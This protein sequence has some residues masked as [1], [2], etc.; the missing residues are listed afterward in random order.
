MV[1]YSISVLTD[2]QQAKL[3][4]QSF[5]KQDWCYGI[6]LRDGFTAASE[7]PPDPWS[8]SVVIRINTAEI[9]I[10]LFSDLQFPY[11]EPRDV[12]LSANA[13]YYRHPRWS[14]VER[15]TLCFQNRNSQLLCQNCR[16]KIRVGLF[17]FAQTTQSCRCGSRFAHWSQPKWT[18]RVCFCSG[19]SRIKS[20]HCAWDSSG[21]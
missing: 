2:L 17:P 6:R 1:W 5:I 12:A 19:S 13:S 8:Y 18:W 10:Q 15:P 14:W 7:N 11:K 3:H 16:Q 9:L 20:E 21:L 4:K